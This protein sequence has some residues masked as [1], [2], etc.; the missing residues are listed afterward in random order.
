M[1]DTFLA[2]VEY[3]LVKV[4][5]GGY[6][7]LNVCGAHGKSRHNLRHLAIEANG[8]FRTRLSTQRT[9]SRQQETSLVEY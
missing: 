7:A 9:A 2:Q 5:N 4:S 1:T 8:R 6:Q 3:D